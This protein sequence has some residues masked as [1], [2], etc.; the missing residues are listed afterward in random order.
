MHGGKR[1]GAGR[2][3]GSKTKRTVEREKKVEQ[4]AKVLEET[5]PD[6]FHGDAHALLM[7]VYK[8]QSHPLPLRIDAAKAAISFEK[9]KLGAVQHSG[10]QTNPV[11]FNIL[12]G[13]PLSD[14]DADSD[15]HDT[16]H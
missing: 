6:A 16:Q 15:R 5:L 3:A 7:A 11:A 1:Q 14:A 8:D 10:D 9:P 2:K 4:M 12:T 13:V